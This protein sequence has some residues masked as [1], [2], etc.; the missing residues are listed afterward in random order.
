MHTMYEREK[1]AACVC[2]GGG[3]KEEAVVLPFS[4]RR[5]FSDLLFY[6]LLNFT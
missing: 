5:G 4:L 2:V 6:A 1:C 3:R